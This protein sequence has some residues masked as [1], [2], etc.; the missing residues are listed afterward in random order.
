M[1]LMMVELVNVALLIV[2]L[3]V[4]CIVIKIYLAVKVARCGRRA[5]QV[6]G[7][8]MEGEQRAFPVQALGMEEEQR[9]GDGVAVGRHWE[10]INHRAAGNK[11]RPQ[12]NDERFC[13]VSKTAV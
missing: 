4:M 10:I 5:F 1:Q 2:M 9:A 3:I 8:E 7:P 6:L 11:A 12:E 13:R